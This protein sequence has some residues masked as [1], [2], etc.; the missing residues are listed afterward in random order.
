MNGI[1]GKAQDPRLYSGIWSLK[2][3]T[4]V[5]YMATLSLM[6][7]QDLLYPSGLPYLSSIYILSL[8]ARYFPM[9]LLFLPILYAFVGIRLNPSWLLAGFIVAIV[10]FVA[11]EDLFVIPSAISGLILHN[12]MM[13]DYNNFKSQQPNLTK[14]RQ[15]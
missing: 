6:I 12:Q 4:L 14:I 1:Y 15:G 10:W 13:K 11:F 9:F 7:A 8:L 3:V 5:V 2:I